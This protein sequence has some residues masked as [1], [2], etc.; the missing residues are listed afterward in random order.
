M[1][2]DEFKVRLVDN[3]Q[4]SVDTI[5][6]CNGSPGVVTHVRHFLML[7]ESSGN[8]ICK[9][10]SCSCQCTQLFAQLSVHPERSDP[11]GCFPV[12]GSSIH[13][14]FSSSGVTLV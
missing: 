10:D 2:E 9:G 5:A 13:L 8:A 7:V 1:C 12:R 3:P 6:T 14:L 4:N 11:L